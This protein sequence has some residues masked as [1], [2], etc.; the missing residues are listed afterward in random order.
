MEF[1]RATEADLDFITEAV[2]AAVKSGT[3]ILSYA[4]LFEK[5]E[6]EL[7]PLFREMIEEDIE[8]QEL[9]L[10]G[11]LMAKDDNGNPAATCC[12]WVEG[13]EGPS[14]MLTA[15]V[16]SFGLGQETYKKALKKHEIIESLRVDRTEG[17]LQF[18]HVYT[19][20]EY[21][22]QGLA[23]Q[24]IEEQIKLKKAQNP[25]LKKAEIILFKTNESALKAY[26]KLGFETTFEQHSQH[27]GILNYFPAAAR[28]LMSMDI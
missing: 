28:V 20:P 5:S 17:A 12:T 23:A 26:Q 18:E 22:G 4:T 1:V 8:G 25:E 15:Q 7:K 19:A 13:E 14:S 2:F 21:R 3:D 6:E 27:P 10:S 16:L 24:V 9:W 11:F